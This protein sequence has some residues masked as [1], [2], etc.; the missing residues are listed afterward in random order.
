MPVEAE[1]VVKRRGDGKVAE[2]ILPYKQKFK[3]RHLKAVFPIV[4]E[5]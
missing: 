2:K 1:V 4:R 5:P 3:N